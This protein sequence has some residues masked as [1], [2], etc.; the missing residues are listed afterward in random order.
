MIGNEQRLAERTQGQAIERFGQLDRG[1]QAQ[2][3]VVRRRD[4]VYPRRRNA[5]QRR[6]RD[7]NRRIESPESNRATSRMEYQY[8]VVVNE[9]RMPVSGL[10]RNTVQSGGSNARIRAPRTQ[11]TVDGRRVINDSENKALRM[12][13][14][15]VEAD[16][17]LQI[18]ANIDQQNEAI[19]ARNRIA[20]KP[21]RQQAAVERA[22]DI[23]NDRLAE[24]N[25]TRRNSPNKTGLKRQG[26][27]T[28]ASRPANTLK[29]SKRIGK[30]AEASK[31]ARETTKKTAKV[32]R[33]KA[34]VRA[35][36]GS[37]K[38][39]ADATFKDGPQ[40]NRG[41]EEGSRLFTPSNRAKAA[42]NA[43]RKTLKDGVVKDR[44]GDKIRRSRSA[45]M[46][47][48]AI[49]KKG[50]YDL[51]FR[52][53]F[54]GSYDRPS[55]KGRKDRR[56][57]VRRR[58]KGAAT[59]DQLGL[60]MDEVKIGK[61]VTADPTSKERMRGYRMKTK[62]V[63]EEDGSGH[64]AAT[65]TG[66]KTWDNKYKED[67][68]FDPKSLGEELEE[69]AKTTPKQLQGRAIKGGSSLRIKAKDVRGTRAKTPTKRPD[70]KTKT[71]RKREKA[72]RKRIEKALRRL[73]INTPK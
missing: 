59:K 3:N 2:R 10:A 62:G 37:G 72:S 67:V 54:N 8:D 34:S 57:N 30:K 69:L 58:L 41:G 6:A 68:E 61:D 55:E 11:N 25:T 33:S 22:K 66:P 35:R 51:G 12:R 1:Q 7:T 28:E 63:L 47:S 32:E 65:R 21:K 73:K 17:Q 40:P 43:A 56:S 64:V 50:D 48:Y 46:E 14:R 70:N 45:G 42:Q 18:R 49:D 24:A 71:Y 13:E 52:D 31:K 36:Q 16:R 26:Y 5:D 20:G 4:E 15:Q 38:K 27:A 39:K 44:Y 23:G 9:D 29:A 19:A 53:S 60:L